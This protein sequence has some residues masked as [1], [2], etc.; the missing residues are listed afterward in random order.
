MKGITRITQRLML[1]FL[2][3]VAAITMF[4]SSPA[5]AATSSVTLLT[6]DNFET[7]VV[8]SDKPVIVVL[9]SRPTLEGYQTSLENLK[10]EAEKFFGDK[11]K[12]VVGRDE[13]N[14][15]NNELSVPSPRIFPPF[16]TIVAFKNGQR[17]AGAFFRPGSSTSAFEYV[18]GELG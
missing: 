8:K 4:L 2:A 17:V 1:V 18:K 7:E 11:Y 10:S 9:A 12:V 13:E 15:Y 6:P 5:V 14:Y 16:P 3:L